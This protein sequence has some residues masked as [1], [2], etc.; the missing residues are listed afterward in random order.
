MEKRKEDDRH[1][2]LYVYK[3]DIFGQTIIE[4][5]KG[6]ILGK[7]KANSVG[8]IIVEDESGNLL[9]KQKIDIFDNTVIEN[10]KGKKI[11]FSRKTSLVR[12]PSF[13][14][15]EQGGI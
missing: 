13:L 3:R 7:Q 1:N 9:I 5:G 11:G 14:K 4:D 10:Q 2:T 8:E 6:R 12:K 15:I